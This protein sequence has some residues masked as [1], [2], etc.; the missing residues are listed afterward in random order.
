MVKKRISVFSWALSAIVI[1]IVGFGLF[2]AKGYL[3]KSYELAQQS[4][5]KIALIHAY[6]AEKKYFAKAG[7]YTDDLIDLGVC[8]LNDKKLFC[9]LPRE[10]AYYKLGFTSGVSSNHSVDHVL[11]NHP[12]EK[13]KVKFISPA[14]VAVEAPA[15]SLICKDCLAS[16]KQFKL[17]AYGIIGT[18]GRVDAWTIDQDKKIQHFELPAGE[19]SK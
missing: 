16:E 11:V 10:G 9:G 14:K 12:T 19:S 15:L 6:D 18:K 13:E 1:A 2:G 3:I 7:R 17:V 8:N 5:A 4:Q